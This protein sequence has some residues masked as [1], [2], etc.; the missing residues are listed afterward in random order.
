[1]QKGADIWILNKGKGVLKS[2]V[3]AIEKNAQ[4]TYTFI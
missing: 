2:L 4:D 1:M 3:S